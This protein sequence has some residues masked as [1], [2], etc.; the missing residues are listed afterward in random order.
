MLCPTIVVAVEPVAGLDPVG[1]EA[2]QAAGLDDVGDDR[3][4]D[5]RRRR[6]CGQRRVRVEVLVAAPGGVAAEE[7]LRPVVLGDLGDG[8]VVHLDRLGRGTRP[9]AGA[10]RSPANS[11]YLRMPPLLTPS[12]SAMTTAR[13][14]AARRPPLSAQ[15]GA[16]GR[17]AR[18]AFA[19]RAR[20]PCARGGSGRR[21]RRA[22]G[23]AGIGGA[24]GAVSAAATSGVATVRPNR[25]IVRIMTATPKQN[26]SR[27]M[28]GCRPSIAT[29]RRTCRRPRTAAAAGRG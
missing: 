5:R 11:S 23:A 15:R 7:P 19:G 8:E 9:A 28:N 20:R 14:P 26:S 22:T 17:L 16:G 10:P 24:G 1:G 4:V 27:P 6:W 13:L 12:T 25:P 29:P 18:T 21:R 2:A 3:D